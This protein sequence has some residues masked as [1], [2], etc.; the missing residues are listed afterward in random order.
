MNIDLDLNH[1]KFWVFWWISILQFLLN[2]IG[3][4]TFV[5]NFFATFGS[6]S[7]LQIIAFNLLSSAQW[8]FL[9]SSRLYTVFVLILSLD[10]DQWYK[11]AFL[12]VMSSKL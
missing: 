6:V 8:N 11:T 1:A 3:L 4:D 10:Y 12:C 9:R 2:R 7:K 5:L